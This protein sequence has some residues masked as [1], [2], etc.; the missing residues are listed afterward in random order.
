MT[1]EHW[2]QV[3]AALVGIATGLAILAGIMALTAAWSAFQLWRFDRRCRKE[4][5]RRDRR[6]H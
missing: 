6:R 5:E 3:I 1:P 4:D 2:M